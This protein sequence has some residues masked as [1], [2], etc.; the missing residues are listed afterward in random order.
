MRAYSMEEHDGHLE[1]RLHD[2]PRPVPSAGELLVRVRA[3]GMNRGELLRQYAFNPGAGE[4]VVQGMECA[5]E[6]VALGDS[7][8]GV[9]VGDR[10]MGRCRGAYAEYSLMASCDIIPVPEN[11]DWTQA[12]AIPITYMVACDMLLIQGRLA[13]DEWLLVAGVTSGVGVACMQIAK[14]LGARVIGTSGSRTKLQVLAEL[15]LD[16][17]ICTRGGE[18]HEQVLAATGGQGANLVVDAVGGSVLAECVRAMAFAGRLA[19]VGYV[20]RVLAAELDL[21]ALH[22][23][24][25][26]L[27][28]VSAKALQPP[29]RKTIVDRVK[30]ELLPMFASG[31][32]RPLVDEVFAFDRINAAKARMEADLHVGKLVIAGAE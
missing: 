10:V 24:R 28:G 29:Q 19:V 12:A 30:T 23:K 27:F 21:H 1:F 11:L 6:V 3:A 9:S 22:A 13:R 31:R 26:V 32:L 2:V 15:G 17:G 4:H 14:A 8:V 5:G 16:H 20:D 18:F 7:V 25:L